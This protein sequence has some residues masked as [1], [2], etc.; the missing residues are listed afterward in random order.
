M[1]EGV[2]FG[3]EQAYHMEVA[4]RLPSGFMDRPG[5]TLDEAGI[6]QLRSLPEDEF[7]EDEPPTAN[8]E[9]A[10]PAIVESKTIPQLQTQPT[11]M[12]ATVTL[13]AT[14]E[15]QQAPTMAASNEEVAREIRRANFEMLTQPKGVKSR[16][17]AITGLSPANISHRLHGHKIFDAETG[18]FFC[19]ALGLPSGWFE[20]PQTPAS[21]PEATMKLLSGDSTVKAVAPA[22]Q[23]KATSKTTLTKPAGVALA[24]T[25]RSNRATGTVSS[26]ALS[27]AALGAPKAS[28]P[29][30]GGGTSPVQPEV[31]VKRK[32]V[33]V[34]AAPVSAPAPAAAV[35]VPMTPAPILPAASPAVASLSAAAPVAQAYLLILTQKIQEG[36]LP[37]S[38]ALELLQEAL[39]L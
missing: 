1:L 11:H 35:P 8:Q 12:E 28:I 24:P 38:R 16:L 30:S 19:Q 13:A 20:T 34:V 5:A 14:P 23:P 2:N 9:A 31:T 21:I 18:E 25:K 3:P 4:L 10:P 17:V 7:H 27:A 6:A 32:K 33:G 26:L 15:I 22:R 39:V 37:E 29:Q 36:R